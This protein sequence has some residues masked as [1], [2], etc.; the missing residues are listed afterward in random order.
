MVSS[1]TSLTQSGLRDWIVQRISSLILAAYAVFLIFFVLFHSPLTFQV[2]HDLFQH[3][4]M[5]VFSFLALLSMV[6]HTWIG[7]WTVL[8]DYIK[9]AY[10]RLTLLVLVIAALLSYLVWGIDIIWGI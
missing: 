4:W 5:R 7:I 6:Y 1:V 9:C 2:W 3:G 8:T 10:F